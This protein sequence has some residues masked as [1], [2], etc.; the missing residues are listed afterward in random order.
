LV[1]DMPDIAHVVQQGVHNPWLF[2]PAA[3]LLGALHAL[4]PGH[5]KSMMAAYIIAVRGS[6]AQAIVL[7]VSAAIGHTLVI[8]GLA[9]TGLWLGDKLIIDKA[10]PWLELATGLLIIALGARIIV[11]LSRPHEHDHGIAGHDHQHDHDHDHDH[12]DEQAQALDLRRRLGGRAVTTAE[13]A[14]F[15]LSAGLLPCPAAFA[16]LLVCLQMKAFTL[17][18]A[19]VAA[20]SIG[21]AIT[22]VGIGVAA[23]WTANKASRH[24]DG[25]D[26]WAHRLPY[27]SAA[28][29][30]VVGAAISLRGLGHLG[31]V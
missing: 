15:G 22:L 31:V 9:L 6:V 29:V 30:M 19:L 24:L 18:V 28:I 12:D 27:V 10:E 25:F 23:A 2:L 21:L 4:E 1:A 20:F 14:W 26:A 7:G 5:S 17:G 13:V 16:V 8:W 3:V 11:L